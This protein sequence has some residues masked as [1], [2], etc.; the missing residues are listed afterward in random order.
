MRIKTSLPSNQEFFSKYADLLP[1]LQLSTLVANIISAATEIFVIYTICHIKL[2]QLAPQFAFE[3][4][5]MVAILGTLFLELGL[6]KFCPSAAKAI[7]YKRFQGLERWLTFFIFTICIALILAS[8]TLSFQGSFEIVENLTG[9]AVEVSMSPVNER[10]D[11][12]ESN[13]L[14]NYQSD[15]SGIEKRFDAQITAAESKYDAKIDKAKNEYQRLKRKESDNGIS[16]KTK[17]SKL[18][19]QI[20]GHKASKANKVADLEKEKSDALQAVLSGKTKNLDRLSRRYDSDKTDV[21]KKNQ[22]AEARRESKIELY[23]AGLGYFTL[24]C[25]F[26]FIVCTIIIEIIKKGSG[27]EETPTPTSYFFKQGILSETYEIGKEHIQR[28]FYGLLRLWTNRIKPPLAP[29]EKEI[30]ILY[31]LTNLEQP[32]LKIDFE[33]SA[34]PTVTLPP[35]SENVLNQFDGGTATVSYPKKQMGFAV[36]NNS[37]KVMNAKIAAETYSHKTIG[38]DTNTSTNINPKKATITYSGINNEIEPREYPYSKVTSLIS[39]YKGRVTDS[40]KKPIKRRT[41]KDKRVLANN[42]KWL[43]YWQGRVTE[44]FD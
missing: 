43:S 26:V 37:D 10:R 34:H 20:D 38:I 32:R 9:E 36:G 18:K 11:G 44:F 31:D 30:P 39:K 7:L 2:M 13:I 27:I 16:Y 29:S 21:K 15:K 3:V 33:K 41:E 24:I 14:K 12:R 19:A 5:V 8:A 22:K 17:K 1:T 35:F 23:G 6:R 28:I 40:K 42:E 4:S 25:L